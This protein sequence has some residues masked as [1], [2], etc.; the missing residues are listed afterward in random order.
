MT[1]NRPQVL[2][3]RAALL[4]SR[5]GHLA[6]AELFHPEMGFKCIE[7]IEVLLQ[8]AC[9]QKIPADCLLS[10]LPR[11]RSIRPNLLNILE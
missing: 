10:L 1:K 2:R 11:S 5:T 3:L 6:H 9:Q 8:V 4:L 7:Q